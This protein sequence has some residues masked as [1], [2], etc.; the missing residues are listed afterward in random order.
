MNLLLKNN[1]VEADSQMFFFC[2][3]EGYNCWRVG[4]G[5]LGQKVLCNQ[6]KSHLCVPGI[7]QEWR[8]RDESKNSSCCF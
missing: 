8:A 4:R 5:D 7:T 6:L 1:W 2:S 3:L